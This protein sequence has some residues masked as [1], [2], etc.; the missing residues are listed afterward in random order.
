M[1]GDNIILLSYSVRRALAPLKTL[2]DVIDASIETFSISCLVGLYKLTVCCQ[3]PYV[4]YPLLVRYSVTLSTDPLMY[5]LQTAT[6][7]CSLVLA[8][9]L[10]P[11]LTIC[12]GTPL[13]C[14]HLSILI[15]LCFVHR[16]PL[17]AL[18]AWFSPL[19]CSPSL[20]PISA[21]CLTPDPTPCS[22]LPLAPQIFLFLCWLL[23]L[24]FW[25]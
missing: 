24:R 8:F 9:S 13:F 11:P 18:S 21:L 10:I 5:M 20:P 14:L 22:P 7:S 2:Q 12:F 19:H 15:F 17:P 23:P 25:G 1:W 6:F 4:I 16:H 3:L